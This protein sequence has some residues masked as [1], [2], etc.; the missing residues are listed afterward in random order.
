MIDKKIET[1]I[2]A[3]KG[4]LELW[5]KFHAVYSEAISKEIIAKEDE[6]R[7]FETLG[8]IKNKY[9]ELTASLDMKYM[10]HSRL[11]DPVTDILAIG[12]IRLMSEKNLKKLNE[13]WRD[14]YIFLNNILEKLKNRKKMLEEFNPVGVFFKKMFMRY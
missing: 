4:F 14:S 3:V 13:D 5:M 1:N 9:N 2:K 10:P 7:F 11:T 8:M 6:G 12:G